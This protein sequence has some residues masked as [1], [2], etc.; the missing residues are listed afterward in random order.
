M[1][2]HAYRIKWGTK[3]SMLPVC[4]CGWGDDAAEDDGV[5][6]FTE[7]D[8]TEAWATNHLL[9]V[10]ADLERAVQLKG[11]SVREAQQGVYARNARIDTLEGSLEEWRLDF[12]SIEAENQRLTAR[13][14]ELEG[15]RDEAGAY[16]KML[17]DGLIAENQRL[18]EARCPRCGEWVRDFPAL[19]PT[20][21]PGE[22]PDATG[23]TYYRPEDFK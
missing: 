22:V 7:V 20:E 15:E 3:G 16:G 17:N 23:Q 1:T 8:A 6:F 14:A 4:T 5:G 9:Q 18:R 11:E 2:V 10:I 21:E 12:T 13:I 19:T